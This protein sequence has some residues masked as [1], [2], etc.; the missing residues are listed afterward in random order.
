[1]HRR[2]EQTE[3]CLSAP[4]AATSPPRDQRDLQPDSTLYR[5]RKPAPRGYMDPCSDWRHAP[6][7][8]QW[9]KEGEP[10][11]VRFSSTSHT[12]RPYSRQQNVPTASGGALVAALAPCRIGLQ[13][14]LAGDPSPCPSRHRSC[15][16]PQGRRCL[17]KS[18]FGKKDDLHCYV[19]P[20]QCAT[21]TRQ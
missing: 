7:T 11:C 4:P 10:T 14:K 17:F 18:L 13:L 12:S 5:N 15:Q 20:A 9:T 6:A 8:S 16:H 3:A 21:T 2:L 19:Q 1:M